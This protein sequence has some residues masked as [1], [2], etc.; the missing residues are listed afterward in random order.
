MELRVEHPSI[1]V[2]ELPSNTLYLCHVS[3]S[4]RFT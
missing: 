1:V 3:C 2:E 4:A